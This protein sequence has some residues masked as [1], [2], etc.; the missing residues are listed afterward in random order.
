MTI[1]VFVRITLG[2][3]VIAM[4]MVSFQAYKTTGINQ[5]ETIKVE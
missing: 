2:A 4:V 1:F 5:A 3:I